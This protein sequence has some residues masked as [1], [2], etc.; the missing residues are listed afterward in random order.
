MIAWLN[1]INTA[2]TKVLEALIALVFLAM[3]VLIAVLVIQ[4]YLFSSGLFGGDELLEYLF[5]YTST[6]GA[7]VVLARREHVGIP[8]FWQ[9]MK[10]WARKAFDTTN[11]LVIMVLNV[12]MLILSQKWIAGV[13]GSLSTMLRIPMWV[14]EIALPIGCGLTVLY[15]LLNILG[16]APRRDADG[17]CA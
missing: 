10:P 8:V 16:S 1:R 4:R 11:H 5:I 13:G 14:V 15:G 3:F 2:A 6:I 9:R 7:A 17:G 12:Y